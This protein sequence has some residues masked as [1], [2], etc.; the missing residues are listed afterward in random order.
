MNNR[1]IVNAKDIISLKVKNKQDEDL[2]K[3]E[4]IML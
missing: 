3:I 4:A 2:G 1:T